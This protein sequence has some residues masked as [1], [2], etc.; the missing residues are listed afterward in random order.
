MVALYIFVPLKMFSST[1][2]KYSGVRSWAGEGSISTYGLCLSIREL[3][4]AVNTHLLRLYLGIPRLIIWKM[5]G[6]IATKQL[7]LTPK[8]KCF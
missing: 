6:K 3:L 2:E 8:L 1:D 4:Q 7:T 5:K